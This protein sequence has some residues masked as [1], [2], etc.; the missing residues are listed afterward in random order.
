MHCTRRSFAPHVAGRALQDLSTGRRPLALVGLLLL[1]ACNN[2]SNKPLTSQP[3]P[4]DEA[5]V[6][7]A[8]AAEAAAPPNPAPTAGAPTSDSAPPDGASEDT[9]GPG[10]ADCP[11]REAPETGPVSLLGAPLVIA[12]TEHG[13][14]INAVL[15]TGVPADLRARVAR[16]PEASAATSPTRDGGAPQATAV[17]WWQLGP[18]DSPAPDIAEWTVSNLDPGKRYRYE[19]YRT[20]APDETAIF[21]GSAVTQRPAGDSFEFALLTDSHI[22]PPERVFPGDRCTNTTQEEILDAVAQDIEPLRPDF[23]VNLGDMLDFHAWGFNPPSP[24]GQWT[25]LGYLNYRRLLG[26]LLGNAAHFP[27]VGNWDGE[28]GCFSDAEINR[29]LEQRLLYAPGPTPSTYPQGGGP[30]EDYYAFTWG[31]ALFVVLNVMTYTETCHL[32]SDEG[33]TPEDWTLGTEQMAWFEQTLAEASSRWRFVL[34]H[35]VVGGAG[36]TP[37]NANYGRG[38]GLSACIGEQRQVHELMHQSGVQAFFFGHDHVFTDMVVDDIHYT[39]PG[40]AGAPWKFGTS[41]TGYEQYWSDSGFARVRVSPSAVQV[42]FLAIGGEVLYSYELDNPREG[43]APDAGA[44]SLEPVCPANTH[45]D[46]GDASGSAAPGPA[47]IS[48]D[49]STSGVSP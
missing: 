7:G 45:L 18:P 2:N 8:G 49:A 5:G 10:A 4:A 39:L 1:A 28:N 16:N 25:R 12:P 11:R 34:I 31:D 29:S 46:G 26:D 13:F 41:E 35:H 20:G 47:P 38:G 36:G 17:D 42:D 33:G 15:G 30:N 40:S 48:P 19:I 37:A 9:D 43:T 22:H 23:V 27:V 3:N 44:N 14:G 21:S 32:L 24:S 6:A